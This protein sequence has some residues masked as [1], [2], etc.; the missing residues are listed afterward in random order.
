MTESAPRGAPAPRSP[1]A[2]RTLPVR[3]STAIFAKQPVAGLVKTRLAPRLAPEAC[4]SLAGAMLADLATRLARCRSGAPGVAFDP[5]GAEAWFRAHFAGLA[6]FWPQ[7]GRDLAERLEHFFAERFAEDAERSVVVVGADAPLARSEEVDRAHA[8]LAA[9][10]DLALG[11]D[12]GGGYYLIGLARPVPELFREVAMSTGDM[13]ERTLE[14][15]R[16][17]GL[18]VELLEPCFDVDLPA[19]LERLARAVRELEGGPAEARALSAWFAAHAPELFPV[20]SR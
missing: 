8:A 14:L 9:G 6:G 19:D 18:A 10:A 15:A 2:E 16:R 3:G 7:R 4:A 13:A 1:A 12:Q 11:P 5:P 17:A 20:R